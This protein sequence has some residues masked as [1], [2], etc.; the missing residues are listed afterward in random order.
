M[1]PGDASQYSCEPLLQM[2]A[3][4]NIRLGVTDV[5]VKQMNSEPGSSWFKLQIFL[6]P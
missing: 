1:Q 6:E 5:V 4:S 3:C 2:H